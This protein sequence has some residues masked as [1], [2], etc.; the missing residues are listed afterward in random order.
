MRSRSF[1]NPL[2]YGP[3]LLGS[4]FQSGS[5]KVA[6]TIAGV[7]VTAIMTVVNVAATYLAFRYIDKIGRRKLSMTGYTGMAL[8]AVLAAIGLGYL[9]GTLKIVV[10]MIGLDL[11]IASFAM[12]VGGT[13]WLIQ[14]EVFSTAARGRAAAIAAA[15]DW[16]ANFALIEA[17]PKLQG[18]IG[19]GWVLIIFAGLCV[20][21]ITF[22][23]LFLPETKGHSVEEITR[24]FDNPVRA[25]GRA[26]NEAVA[27]S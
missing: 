2:Y 25:P 23:A 17:F 24:L 4:L 26:S 8:S 21:A 19:L 10:V 13:G 15:V 22:I 12:G 7:E 16:L 5:S 3:H 20:L 18:A 11:F 14:G 1:N 9:A 27:D 6:T